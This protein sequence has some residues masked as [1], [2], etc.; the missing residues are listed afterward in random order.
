MHEQEKKNQSSFKLHLPP[1]KK[2]GT[3]KTTNN[4]NQSFSVNKKKEQVSKKPQ[5][6]EHTL[7]KLKSNVKKIFLH[8]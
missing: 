2:V 3:S 4:G 8:G 5:S 7:P 6:L 1:F